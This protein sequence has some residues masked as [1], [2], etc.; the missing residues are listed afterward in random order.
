VAP[1]RQLG[2]V[3]GAGGIAGI[4]WHIGVLHGLA[5]GGADITSA[6]RLIGTS[7]GA[8]VAAQVGGGCSVDEL[9]NRHVYPTSPT[10]EL[11]PELSVTELWEQMIPI[12]AESTDEDERRRRLGRLALDAHTV[13][14]GVRR[15]VIAARL[16]GVSWHGAR[17][18]VEACEA[19]TGRRRV[20][21]AASGI[22]VVDAVAASC[23]VPGVW[24]PVT[25]DGFRYLDG[26]IW[27][28]TNCDLAT[29]CERVVVI[30]PLSDRAM[31]A[32]LAGLGGDVRSVVITPDGAS[33]AAFGPDVLDPAVQKASARAGM[34]QRLDEADRIASLLAG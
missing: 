27:S 15:R 30:A 26:G 4:A 32:E 14:E 19:T 17:V 12:Y 5:Q 29:G 25:L 34:A 9:F 33:I 7:A 10:C 6:D 31:D 8:T 20:F 28:L 16:L 18:S 1:V 2:L 23:A 13:D 21:D 11:T 22:D 24:P 3:L